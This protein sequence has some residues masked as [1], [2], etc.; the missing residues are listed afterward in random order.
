VDFEEAV[1]ATIEHGNVQQNYNFTN[2]RFSYSSPVTP[3][4]VYDYDIEHKVKTE[5]KKTVGQAEICNAVS[6][7]HTVYSRFQ[8]TIK[9][10]TARPE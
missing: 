9:G 1:Y 10:R 8:T 6:T 3:P 7:P 4:I 5:V 2:L